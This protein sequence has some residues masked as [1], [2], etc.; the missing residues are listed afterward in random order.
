MAEN[1][2]ELREKIA[3]GPV[4]V[5][6]PSLIE[7]ELDGNGEEEIEPTLLPLPPVGERRPRGRPLGSKNR[8][9]EAFRTW[10]LARY[11]SPL[12][13]LCEMYSRSV[14]ALAREMGFESDTRRA[15]PEELLELLKIQ[16]QCLKEVAPYVHSRQPI[17]IDAGQNGLV[18]LTIGGMA[19]AGQELVREGLMRANFLEEETAENGH[20][21]ETLPGNSV[22]YNSVVLDE[23]AGNRATEEAKAPDHESGEEGGSPHAD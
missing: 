4:H 23:K 5:G 7:N 14:H 18:N 10:L 15:K 8:A 20:F 16:L 1:L 21:L 12:V 3:S 11:T 22:A 13:G 17:A 2:E 19:A 9:S 6:L